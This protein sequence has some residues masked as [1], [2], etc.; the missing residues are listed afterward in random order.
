MNEE[1]PEEVEMLEASI[2][3]TR[4]F[5]IHQPPD[6]AALVG[7]KDLQIPGQLPWIRCVMDGRCEDMGQS[8]P[9]A[10]LDS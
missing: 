3:M 6:N 9:M 4:Q 1:S 8:F 10:D 5:Q 2:R 7:S